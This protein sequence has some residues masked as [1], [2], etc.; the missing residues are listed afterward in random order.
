MSQQINLYDPR[1]RKQKQHFSAATLL[2]ALAAVLVLSAAVQSLYAWQNRTLQA[3]L[4]QA[5][6]RTAALQAQTLQFARELGGQGAGAAV[7]DELAR[8]EARLRARR[9]L[10]ATLQAGA[11][12]NAE[13]F[14]PYLAALARRTMDGVWLTGVDIGALDRA[15]GARALVL[16]GRVLQAALVPSYI[17]SLDNE[18]PFRGRSVHELRVSAKAERAAEFSLTIPLGG[19]PS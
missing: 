16:R 10:L 1:F 19:G 3:S 2:V 18:A 15:G 5:E 8:L 11:G 14:S 4:A 6:Q 7:G 13:G 17:R 9:D 12:G